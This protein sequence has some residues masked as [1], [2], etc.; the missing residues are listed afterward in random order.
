MT[1]ADDVYYESMGGVATRLTLAGR[2][3]MFALFMAEMAP[4][5]TDRVLDIGAS[6]VET[7]EANIIEKLYPWPDNITAAG[8]GDPAIFKKVHPAAKFVAI[9]PHAQLPFADQSFDLV[10]SNAVLEHVG[11]PAQRRAFLLEA[12]RVGRRCFITIP[13]RWFPVEHHTA[14]PL[15]HFHPPT[16]RFTCRMLT[17]KHWSNPQNLDFLDRSLIAREWPAPDRPVR[18][19]RTGLPLGPFSSNLAVIA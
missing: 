5:R 12:L 8:L 1:G 4:R 7:A 16:F 10:V 17:R 19:L 6:T 2:R 9:E 15:L 14:I 13:N 18:I 3:A 11:G